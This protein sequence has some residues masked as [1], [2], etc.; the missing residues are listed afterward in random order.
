[1]PSLENQRQA[2]EFFLEHFNSQETF[3]KDDFDPITSW[4]KS[5]RDTYWSKQFLGFLLFV[6][7]GGGFLRYFPRP[8]AKGATSH[9]GQACAC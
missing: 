7:A 4:T 6:L 9:D 1:M 2:F 3:S 8:K 5:A